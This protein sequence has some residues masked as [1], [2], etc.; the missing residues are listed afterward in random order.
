MN[1]KSRLERFG[2]GTDEFSSCCCA[3]ELCGFWTIPA[4]TWKN[5]D[6]GPRRRTR[7][8]EEATKIAIDRL[9]VYLFRISQVQ[10]IFRAR[11]ATG[12][13]APHES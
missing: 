3:I 9:A 1:R 7:S 8:G 5:R 4:G 12:D 2:P 11:L 6:A 13:F 10:L